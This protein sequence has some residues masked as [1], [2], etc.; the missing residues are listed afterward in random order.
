ML[1]PLQG[2]AQ[3]LLQEFRAAVCRPVI[4]EHHLGGATQRTHDGQH[5]VEKRT[6]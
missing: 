6:Q 4:D 2:Y 5:L 1:E 3:K